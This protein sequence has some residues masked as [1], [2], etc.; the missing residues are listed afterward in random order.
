[1]RAGCRV[2][3]FEA[4]FKALEDLAL[5]VPHR[6]H[7]TG[8]Y[9][10]LKVSG[11]K[12]MIQACASANHSVPSHSPVILSCGGAQMGHEA[13]QA[14][15]ATSSRRGQRRDE[16]L[17]GKDRNSS[18]GRCR[19][20]RTSTVTRVANHSERSRARGRHGPVFRPYTGGR[21]Q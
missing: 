4:P 13:T 14:E 17:R 15:S 3:D 16:S 19:T 20:W 6:G 2:L 21:V 5:F 10:P 7:S 18:S 11:L 12:L 9:E 1:M 8:R